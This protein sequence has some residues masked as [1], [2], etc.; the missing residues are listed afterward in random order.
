M[1]KRLLLLSLPRADVVG[2]DR[3]ARAGDAAALAW[4]EGSSTRFA[5]A[6]SHVPV[7]CQRTIH[8][9]NMQNDTRATV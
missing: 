7:R 8:Q 1:S 6:R 4:L 5:T 9:L 2:N 3:A